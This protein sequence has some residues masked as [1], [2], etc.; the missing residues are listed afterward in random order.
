MTAQELQEKDAA[1]AMDSGFEADLARQREIYDEREAELLARHP[2]K[3]IAVCA[4]EVFVADGDTEVVSRAEA[5]HPDRAILLHVYDPNFDDRDPLPDPVDSCR[6]RK[7][8]AP[9][10]GLD[11]GFEAD[12]ARQREIYDEREAE[13]LARHPGKFIAVC[14]GEVFVADGDTEVVSRAEAAHP[15]RAILLHVYDPNFDDR[16]PLPD[17]V[18]SCR[19]RKALAPEPAPGVG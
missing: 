3:F 16:D 9:E 7:A 13:L 17:P 1:P 10:P 5:A 14:A 19:P 6:P 18:D 4:G 11:A 2:G 8:R 12:L 15:D